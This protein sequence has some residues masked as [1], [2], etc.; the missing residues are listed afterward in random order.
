MSQRTY[1]LSETAAKLDIGRNTMTRHLRELGVLDRQNL[2]AGRYREDPRLV[3]RKRRYTHPVT[4]LTE[5]GR[6]E[7]TEDGVRFISQILSTHW[8]HGAA[9][10]NPLPPTPKPGVPEGT[11]HD[12]GELTV[13]TPDGERAHHR[14]AMVVVFDSPASL[15]H[16]IDAQWCGYEARRDIPEEQLHPDLLAKQS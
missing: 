8:E 3:V 6:T 11:L 14:A 7:V 13:V 2:P 4:G 12:A 15:Q 16:A 10:A 5:Y 9:P 1:S